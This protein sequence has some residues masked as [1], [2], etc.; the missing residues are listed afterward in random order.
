MDFDSIEANGYVI[1]RDM[2]LAKL[3]LR[4]NSVEKKKLFSTWRELKEIEKIDLV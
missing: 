3:V 2:R 4:L 1:T